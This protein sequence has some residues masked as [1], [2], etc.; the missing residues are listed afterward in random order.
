M[1]PASPSAMGPSITALAMSGVE[2]AAAI[3]TTADRATNQSFPLWGL[4]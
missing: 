3:D 4:R 2:S 1:A